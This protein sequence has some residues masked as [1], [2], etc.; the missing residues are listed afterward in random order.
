MT[1]MAGDGVGLGSRTVAWRGVA[2]RVAA[3]GRLVKTPQSFMTINSAGDAEQ[4]SR[5]GIAARL[6]GGW[7]RAQADDDDGSFALVLLPALPCPT[8]PHPTPPRSPPQPVPPQPASVHREERRCG[9]AG[10]R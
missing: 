10:E 9:R 5:A 6:A 7:G 1:S 3:L 8:A 2:W 4:R